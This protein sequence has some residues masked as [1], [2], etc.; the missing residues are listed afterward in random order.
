MY[1]LIISISLLFN[2]FFNLKLKKRFGEY[3]FLEIGF[4]LNF[5]LSLYIISPTVVFIT[6][7]FTVGDPISYVLNGFAYSNET[8]LV[9]HLIRMLVFQLIFILSYLKIRNSKI[10][11]LKS[12][13]FNFKKPFFILFS[14]V[15][16]VSYSLLFGLSG[17]FEGYLES[18]QRYDHLSRPLRLFI[19]IIV[20]F[21]SAFIILFLFF[22]SKFEADLD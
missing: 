13:D 2:L 17:D 16:I 11:R 21:K 22:L 6:S 8:L 14:L 5:F 10:I 7:S 15:L 3:R 1:Y 4:I 12:I 18:Y 20:R 9:I 19:S